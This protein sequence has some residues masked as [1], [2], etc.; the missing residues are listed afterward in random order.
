MKKRPKKIDST[1][2]V[3]YCRV[4]TEEQADEGASLAVQQEKIAQYA[5]TYELEL[6]DMHVDAGVSAKTLDRPALQTALSDLRTG[7]AGGLIV[8]K[9]DRLTRSVRDLQA[10]LDNYFREKYALMAV[11]DQFDT[12]T[13]SGRL[14][15][16]L[17]SM[18]SEWEREVIAERTKEVLQHLKSKG[19][20]LGRDPLGWE[21]TGEL[22]AE[23]RMV[24]KE[25]PEEQKTLK[26]IL[27]LRQ[28]GHS[29]ASIAETL[30][31]KGIATKRGGVWSAQTI[32][33]VLQRTGAGK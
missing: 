4:S 30:S 33:D 32:S 25:V 1:R 27:L 18:I 16:N 11:T 7:Q 19:V 26:L 2:V 31:A 24:F 13:A 20:R 23:G 22:D 5:K 8:M 9:L 15:M 17:L 28:Q 3:G 29:L 6:V 10:L 21:R 12:R 14:M